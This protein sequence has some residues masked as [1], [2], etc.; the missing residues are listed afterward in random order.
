MASWCR[1][2]TVLLGLLLLR[3]S[4]AAPSAD[5]PGT[6]TNTNSIYTATGAGML[7]ARSRRPTS[8]RQL[9]MVPQ[10]VAGSKP[11]A[12]PGGLGPNCPCPCADPELCNPIATPLPDKEVFIYHIGYVGDSIEWMHYDWSLITTICVF[13][14]DPWT[15]SKHGYA[16]LMCHAHKHG[17]RVTFGTGASSSYGR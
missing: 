9:P 3:T 13:G 1:L 7:R 11:C 5:V 17:A 12:E 16:K 10:P 14:H 4:S 6:N 8:R 2:Y 15:T